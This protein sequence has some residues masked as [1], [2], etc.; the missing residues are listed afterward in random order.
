MNFKT[1]NF[2]TKEIL[3]SLGYRTSLTAEKLEKTQ[4]NEHKLA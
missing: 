3:I 4:Q 2:Q 1:C